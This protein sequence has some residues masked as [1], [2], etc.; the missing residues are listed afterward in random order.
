MATS[1]KTVFN[2]SITSKKIRVLGVPLD[3]GQS[4]RGVDMGPSAV[5]VAGLEA[6]LEALGHVVED[7]GNV[8]VPLAETKDPGPHSAKYLSEIAQTCQKH[9]DLVLKALEEGRVPLA[10]G[11]D[12]SMA[13]GTVAGVAEYYRRQNQKIGLLWIDAHSDINTPESS[14]SGNVHG[15]PLAALMGLSVPELNIYDFLPKV[16]ADNCVL[17]GVRDIDQT[18]KENIRK[19]GIHVF[20][21]R[22][23]DERGMRAVME[24]AL[25]LA[26]RNTVGYHVS[27]DMDWVDPEDAPGVGTPVWGGATY[28]EAHLAME[29][30]ADHGRMTS[31][32]IV[33]VNPV[34]DERNQTAEL[35][36]ELALSAF[37][38]K[39]L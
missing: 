36:V 15:M 29:I 14:P 39:I 33:E 12:H 19:A 9:A 32:E 31:F 24:E 18:E 20:T 26:G 16:Q 22:D 37:G 4:R 5:R 28:R 13:A 25:R 10:L 34:L 7:G 38:K 21:M 23:I 3:L 27:L 8:S 11:G 6:K 30:I 2:P 1:P 35:A 17:V